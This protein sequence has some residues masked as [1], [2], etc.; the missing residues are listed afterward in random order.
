MGRWSAAAMALDLGIGIIGKTAGRQG[1][2]SVDAKLQLPRGSTRPQAGDILRFKPGPS[3]WRQLLADANAGQ[4]PRGGGSV[5]MRYSALL[6]QAGGSMLA[7]ATVPL[8]PALPPQPAAPLI[9]VRR[10]SAAVVETPSAPPPPT[11][12]A[13]NRARQDEERL[14]ALI[15]EAEEDFELGVSKVAAMVFSLF[16]EVDFDRDGLITAGELKGLFNRLFEPVPSEVSSFLAEVTQDGNRV[17]DR[18]RFFDFF[19]AFAV[20]ASKLGL[21]LA[22][23]PTASPFQRASTVQGLTLGLSDS[24]RKSYVSPRR[25]SSKRSSLARV[26]RAVSP[27]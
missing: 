25:M 3:Q 2:H 17:F 22:P 1:G 10:P 27:G 6:E 19:V 21:P 13:K 15:G 11:A 8:Q 23:K 24:Q 4:S 14:E 7:A 12:A 5:L 26:L 20:K 16:Q 9:S 18:Q